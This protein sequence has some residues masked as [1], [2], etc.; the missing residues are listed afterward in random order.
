MRW[1]GKQRYPSFTWDQGHFVRAATNTKRCINL[2]E[3]KFSLWLKV[4]GMSS[5]LE[6][7]QNILIL[8][9]MHCSFMLRNYTR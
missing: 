4:A 9:A 2:G 6:V 7:F 1:P 8:L 5:G 3:Q